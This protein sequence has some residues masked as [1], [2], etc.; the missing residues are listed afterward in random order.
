MDN[1]TN[2]IVAPTPLFDHGNALFNFAGSDDL[3]S[4]KA[5]KDYADAL[6]PCVYDDYVGTAKQVLTPAHKEGLRHLHTFHFKKHSRYNLPSDR[7]K[8]VSMNDRYAK[9]P[10]FSS[11]NGGFSVFFE[12]LGPSFYCFESVLIYVHTALGTAGCSHPLDGLQLVQA[13][14]AMYIDIALLQ[15]IHLEL[16]QC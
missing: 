10:P 15:P 12:L 2:Q 11:E 3:S 1:K 4:E 6:L 13:L 14:S 8:L 9:S 5:L 16:R 7:L